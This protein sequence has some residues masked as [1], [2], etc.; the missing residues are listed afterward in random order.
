MSSPSQTQAWS[1]A[2]EFIEKETQ[3]QTKQLLLKSS[4]LASVIQQR[5]FKWL[6]SVMLFRTYTDS[7]ETTVGFVFYHT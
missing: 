6:F 3:Q 1:T 5:E 4:L 2:M 7:S